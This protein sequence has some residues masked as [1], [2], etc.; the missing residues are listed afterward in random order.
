MRRTVPALVLLVLLA[1]LTTALGVAGLPAPASAADRWAPADDAAIHP[2]VQMY[3]RG[4]QCTAN[5]VFT[6]R[7][8]R[9]YVGYAAHCA[10][11]G[12]ATDTDGCEADSLP[13]GT[14]VAFRSGGSLASQGTKVGSGRLAYSSWSTMHRLG[15][16]SPVVC[17][18]NDFALVRVARVD[19]AKVNPSVPGWGG[20]TG[21]DRDGLEAGEQV[22]TYGASSLLGGESGL[23][24]RTGAAVAGDPE[25]EGWSHT[26]YGLPPGVPG[27][28]GSGYLSAGGR[29]V[30]VLSTLGIAPLPGSNNITDLA[31]ALAFAQRHSGIA[32]L[33]LVR[34]TEPFSG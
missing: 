2:G 4:A 12:E 30:G 18:H 16:S 5:F 33:R 1:P 6:D 25:L 32:G 14:R 11:L 27:D 13:L 15:T 17:G 8:G 26:V 28:S 31:R 23:S 29:A 24:P 19:V 34:G 9:V 10:G 3:T 21:V 7:A 20:P 22:W